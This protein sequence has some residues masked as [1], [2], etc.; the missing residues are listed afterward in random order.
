MAT[1]CF[2]S[3]TP[4]HWMVPMP[5]RRRMLPGQTMPW[6]GSN[7]QTMLPGLANLCVKSHT[8]RAKLD[9]RLC[10]RYHAPVAWDVAP[11][12]TREAA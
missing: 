1:V 5:A 6:W 3:T 2:P 12:G 8:F 11:A 7:G 4:G 10:D 9:H